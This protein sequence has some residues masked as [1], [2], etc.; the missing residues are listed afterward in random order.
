M[1]RRVEK[2]LTVSRASA[3]R[4]DSSDPFGARVAR[5]SCNAADV[6]TDFI[7]RTKAQMA[8]EFART[9]PPDDFPKLPDL[10][11]GRYIDPVLWE[12]ERSAV[13]GRS[14]IFVAHS[15]ELNDNGNYRTV[16]VVGRPV[17]L[18]RG[19][20]RVVRA[21]YNA[22]RHRGAPVVRDECGT[23]RLLVCQYHSW[24]YDLAGRLVRVP[25]ERDF[26]GLQFEE[27]S[28]VGVRCEVWGEWIF[29]NFDADAPP[30][31]EWL[32][33]LADELEPIVGADMRVVGRITTTHRCN[34]K[35][36]AEG[37]LEV[38]HAKT[39]HAQTVGNVL[40]P[41]GAAISLLPHGHSRMIT[42]LSVAVMEGGRDSHRGLPVVDGLGEIYDTTNPAYSFFPN[43]IVPFDKVGFPMLQFWPESADVTRLERIWLGP[44]LGLEPVRHP[45]WDRRLEAFE[46]VMG[47][48]THNLE[49]IQRS[50]EAAAHGGIPLNYQERRI[51]HFHAT[52]DRLIDETAIPEHLRVPD[53]LADWVE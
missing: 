2:C 52:I 43:L 37:F 34:W 47:E 41:G 21:F 3:Y 53:L 46:V 38:Y 31:R 50:V 7:D 49:P 4:T 18:V 1:R 30:L 27:R 5:S 15:S 45:T 35:I 26:V 40:R 28:L 23:C 44:T 24:S 36:M 9:A 32:G 10:P 29:V 13:F 51:W 19:E 17:V 14:W 6:D 16:D 8:Y 22:C 25:D 42:P 11:L 20:D 48:D 33:A 12:Q 39:I